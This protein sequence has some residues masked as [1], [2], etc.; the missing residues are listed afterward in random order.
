MLNVKQ[1]LLSLPLKQRCTLTKTSSSSNSVHV[2]FPILRHI[3]VYHQVDLL[4][5]YT[6]WSLKL[7]NTKITHKVIRLTEKWFRKMISKNVHRRVER[8]KV[9]ASH[10]VSGDEHPA[11]VL[12]QFWHCL[13]SLVLT[14]TT[15]RGQTRHLI[16]S[17]NVNWKS[18]AWK[19]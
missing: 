1:C 7:W 4:C 18:L 11:L 8:W 9:S 12:L 5:I 13:Q 19:H 17:D 16:K 3:Q 15:C 2:S 14:Q 10:Q 6:S